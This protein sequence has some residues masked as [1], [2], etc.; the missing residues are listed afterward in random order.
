LRLVV[1]HPEN[2]VMNFMAYIQSDGRG[3]GKGELFKTLRKLL[4]PDMVADITG[5]ML[6]GKFDGFLRNRML[7]H[8]DE[9]DS[10]DNPKVMQKI[11]A[12]ITNRDLILNGKYEKQTSADFIANLFVSANHPMKFDGGDAERRVFY[13]KSTAWPLE[14]VA[15]ELDEM[16]GDSPDSARERS[17]PALLWH[18]QHLDFG[19]FKASKERGQPMHDLPAFNARGFAVETEPFRDETEAEGSGKVK[20]ARAIIS[21]EFPVFDASVG[22]FPKGEIYTW[23]SIKEAAC[24]WEVEHAMKEGEI[25]APDGALSKAFADAGGGGALKRTKINGLATALFAVKDATIWD[26]KTGEQ[27]ATEFLRCSPEPKKKKY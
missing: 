25:A 11:K 10:E 17:L 22:E 14:C 3:I 9:A 12:L 7:V 4:H 27:R 26:A 5:T 24:R 16:L 6:N 19:P 15:G 8:I 1:A 20:F 23:K 13:L 21:G 18:F 2:F